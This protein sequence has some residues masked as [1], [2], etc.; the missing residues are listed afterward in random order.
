MAI[1]NASPKSIIVAGT[2]RKN[3]HRIRTMPTAK[4]TS[5]PPRPAGAAGAAVTDMG[6]LADSL[7]AVLRRQPQG[8]R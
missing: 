5:F 6:L 4:P 3:R 1:E 7:A 8:G 2:G